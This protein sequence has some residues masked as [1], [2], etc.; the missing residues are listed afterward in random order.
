MAPRDQ[1]KYIE[2][3]KNIYERKEVMELQKLL[4]VIPQLNKRQVQVQ[5]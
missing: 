2:L 5:G 4:T 1:Q 3:L